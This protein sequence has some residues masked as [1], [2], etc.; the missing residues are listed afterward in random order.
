[1]K[2]LSEEKSKTHVRYSFA[3]PFRGHLNVDAKGF[4]NIG[5]AAETGCRTI[6]VLRDTNSG[7]GNDQCCR[8]RNIEG[9]RSIASCAA[10]IQHGGRHAIP[11]R[12]SLFSHHARE[13]NQ[14]FGRFTFHSKSREEA[15]NLCIAGPA[16]HQILHCRPSLFRCQVLPFNELLDGLCNHYRSMK[17]ARSCLPTTVMI[18]SG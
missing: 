17:F 12:F 1:M 3:Q 10:R 2:P 14:L 7:T 18:D 8:C 13:G 5:A 9:S 11:E 6:A 15:G 4:E 16:G